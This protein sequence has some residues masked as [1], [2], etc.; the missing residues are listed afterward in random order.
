[1]TGDELNEANDVNVVDGTIDVADAAAVQNITA[2]D[3]G[4]SD[5]DIQAVS[6]THLTL[7]TICSV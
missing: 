1:M 4:A 2:Y 5:Y 3:S 6:Y 7:P